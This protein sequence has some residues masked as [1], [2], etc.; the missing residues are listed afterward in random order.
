MLLRRDSLQWM[1]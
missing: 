1:L